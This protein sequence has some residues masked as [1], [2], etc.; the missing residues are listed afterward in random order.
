MGKRCKKDYK[1]DG[2]PV[3]D[4]ERQSIRAKIKGGVSRTVN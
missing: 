1:V 3:I 2:W 4:S